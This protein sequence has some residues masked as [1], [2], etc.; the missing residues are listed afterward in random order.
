MSQLIAEEFVPSTFAER[1]VAVPFTTPLLSQARLR[2]DRNEK[3]EFLLPNFTGGRGVYVMP[4]KSL[5]SVMTITLHDR[6]LFEE[7][8]AV[9]THT[10]DTI[11][12]AVL[13]VQAMGVAGPDAAAAAEKAM[14]EDSQYL[15]LTQFV[16]VTE[17]LKLV[18]ITAQ[19]LM[20]PGTTA[21]QAVKLARQSLGKVAALVKIAPDDLSNRVERLG[22]ALAPFGL[23]QA[24][25]PGRLRTLLTRLEA[26]ESTVSHW[27]ETD[28]SD[29]AVLA[30]YVAETAK[31]TLGLARDRRAKLDTLCAQPKQVIHEEARFMAAIGEHVGKLS[32][33]MDGWDFIVAMWDQARTKP[34]E[35]QQTAMSEISRLVPIIP[36]EETSWSAEGFD[37]EALEKI[38]RR[39]VRMNEDWRTGAFDMEA[40][41]RIEQ[42]KAAVG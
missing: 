1:G 27:A 16:L 6:L 29:V 7:I 3:F 25:Q 11:R 23:P 5:P 36:K 35:T 32:W 41:M 40:T 38:Q 42:I 31:F 8:E 13:K 33:L 21:E 15:V 20:K 22:T 4:W 28:V 18:G 12:T 14:A 17:L 26:F 2:L 9:P 39:W 37:P 10:P 19:D 24:G 30:R 34:L